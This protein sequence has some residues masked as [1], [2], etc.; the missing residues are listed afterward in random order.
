MH[1]LTR[2]VIRGT[3]V[4]KSDP[5][6]HRAL[7]QSLDFLAI[8]DFLT[9]MWPSPGIPL[10]QSEYTRSFYRRTNSILYPNPQGT[11]GFLR[12]SWNQRTCSS[13][14]PRSTY[15]CQ[16]IDDSIAFLRKQAFG[17]GHSDGSP[18][19]IDEGTLHC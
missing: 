4:Y 18:R 8:V 13:T 9:A 11:A 17:I 19:L 6:M 5:T 15:K 1:R 14:N 3:L 7:K 16:C 2:A 10:I 12:R